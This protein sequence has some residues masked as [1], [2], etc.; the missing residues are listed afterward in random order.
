MEWIPGPARAGARGVTLLEAMIAMVVVT[1][2]AAG[3]IA[4]NAHQAARNGEAR[5][6]TEATALA[7]DM[8]ENM[9]GW[10]YDDPRLAD[11]NAGNN[12]D[13]GDTARSFEGT[14]PTAD[15]GEADLTL[16]GATWTGL[17]ARGDFQR[18]W[19]VAADGTQR[20]I[21]VIVR[22]PQGAG[23]RRV[24]SYTARADMSGVAAP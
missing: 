3:T 7:Q 9:A 17:P 6:I 11:T 4:V 23:F 14:N 8:V 13:L 22:W 10:A 5:R 18:Y 19:N 24:V 12:N 21:A 2:G 20:R 16:N 1:V 15:H